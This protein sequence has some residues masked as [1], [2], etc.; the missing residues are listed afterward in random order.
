MLIC[1]SNFLSSNLQQ[2]F[3][4][5]VT[6]HQTLLSKGLFCAKPSRASNLI[7][8]PRMGSTAV[9]KIP[10]WLDCDP[11]E[12]PCLSRELQ[13]TANI[14]HD[15]SKSGKSLPILFCS[16]QSSFINLNS[17]LEEFSKRSRDQCHS[18]FCFSSKTVSL[19]TLL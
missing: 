9:P 12:S 4:L 14:G 19:S 2:H 8:F 16:L 15:V 17:A 13:L 7:K 18:P 11:G 1:N 3:W 10:V 5:R 6:L